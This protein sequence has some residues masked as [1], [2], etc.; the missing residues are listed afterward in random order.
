[1]DTTVKE[2]IASNIDYEG[3]GFGKDFSN[4]MRMVLMMIYSQF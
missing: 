3:I 1:M 4:I 2:R